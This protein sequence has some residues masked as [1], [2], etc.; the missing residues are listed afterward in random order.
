MSQIKKLVDKF[1]LNPKSIN[2]KDL[3]RVLIHYGFNKINAKG[4]HYKFKH[5]QLK[6]DLVIPVHNN[7]CKDFYKECAKK[8]IKKIK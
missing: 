2:L 8:E 1:L 6:S 5:P 4:S 7:K 3:E